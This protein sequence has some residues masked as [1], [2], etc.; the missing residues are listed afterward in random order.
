MGTRYKPDTGK[1]ATI[2]DVDLALKEI[3]LAEKE[4]QTIDGKAAKEIAAIKERATKEG[5]TL[6]KRIQDTAAK[7][8]AYAE[9]NKGDL[10]KDRKSVE[11]TF[12]I[13]GY[14]KST[15]IRVKKTTLELLKKLGYTG[16]VRLKEEPDK[17][18][19]SNLTDDELK[20]VDACRRVTDDFF[21]EANLEEVNKEL[22]KSAV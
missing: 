3:G 18:A 13:F 10:F 8:A 11:L 5:E 15:S 22:L 17:E 6:R 20:T 16:C 9:Y 14:R 12:G 21:C 1:L 4:L 7:I 2:E 19:M